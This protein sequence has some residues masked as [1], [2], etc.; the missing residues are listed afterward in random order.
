MSDIEALMRR[1]LSIPS[2]SEAE[3]TVRMVIR[4]GLLVT[5]AE[6]G[7]LLVLDEQTNELCFVMTVGNSASEKAL[8]GQRVPV[9]KGITGLAAATLE[10]QIGAPTYKDIHQAARA[11]GS[12]ADPEAV[13]AAP[14]MV[15]E[16]L[17]G[18]ITAASF[19][20]G[21]HFHTRDATLFGGFGALAGVL[22][23]QLR[24]LSATKQEAGVEPVLEQGPQFEIAR[25]I[26][27]ISEVGP[28]AMED[29]VVLLAN[30]ERLVVRR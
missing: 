5:D 17:V 15:G 28:H 21:K 3:N 19:S 29:L 22:I 4:M 13:M 12:A 6:E 27:R 10:V 25:S 8:R 14:M 9:G 1:Y 26:A 2:A 11:D 23:G 24:Q 7:S 18:V 16:R 30:L 20:K